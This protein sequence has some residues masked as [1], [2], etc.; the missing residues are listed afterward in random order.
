MPRLNRPFALLLNALVLVPLLGSAGAP[1]AVEAQA[2]TPTFGG[3]LLSASFRPRGRDE[4]N[5]VWY[6]GGRAK[7][8]RCEPHCVVVNEVPLDSAVMVGQDSLY[9]VVLAGK[10][11]SGQRLKMVL[12]FS[13]MQLVTVNVPVLD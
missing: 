4:L 2:L 8:M 5:G 12:R 13:N 10:F 6:E 3:V 11:R 9:R 1:P 7:L